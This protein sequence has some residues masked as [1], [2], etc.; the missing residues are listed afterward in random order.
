MNNSGNYMEISGKYMENTG[1][2][3]DDRNPKHPPQDLE[4]K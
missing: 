1:T 3:L 2:D 4:I